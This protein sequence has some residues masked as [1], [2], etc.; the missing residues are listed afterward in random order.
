MIQS[1]NS[2]RKLLL[3]SVSTTIG[4]FQNFCLTEAEAHP[5]P[6]AWPEHAALGLVAVPGASKKKYTFQHGSWNCSFQQEFYEIH[7]GYEQIGYL[8][9]VSGAAY[10]IYLKREFRGMGVLHW[11]FNKLN[12]RLIMNVPPG[13]LQYFSTLGFES[14]ARHRYQAKYLLIRERS[15]LAVMRF[16]ND[17]MAGVDDYVQD[18]W[19]GSL[20]LSPSLRGAATNGEERMRAE[21]AKFFR[22]IESAKK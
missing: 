2:S 10:C 15:T 22:G 8:C 13:L 7:A 17:P 19:N 4:A 16:L 5:D 6:A 9:M 21:I 18:Y 14:F 12:V 11:I 20:F 1:P 3:N